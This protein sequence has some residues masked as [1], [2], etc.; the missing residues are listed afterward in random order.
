MEVV[1]TRLFLVSHDVAPMI[2]TKKRQFEQPVAGEAHPEIGM[3][4]PG[5]RKYILA[6]LKCLHMLVTEYAPALFLMG[7][8]V[9]DCHWEK[10][11]AGTGGHV[12]DLMHLQMLFLFALR[13]KRGRQQ[14]RDA[15]LLGLLQWLSNM[16]NLPA[17]TWSEEKLEASIGTVA[18]GAGG[19]MTAKNAKEL[20]DLYVT[21]RLTGDDVR[22]LDTNPMSKLYPEE[23]RRQHDEEDYQRDDALHPLRDDKGDVRQGSKPMV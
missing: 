10:H 21:Q 12:K 2:E 14:Y 17:M 13:P 1:V 22:D 20:H 5:T 7:K 23:S 4:G 11:A 3:A 9:R 6:Q 15:I 16:D 18:H 8:M 19:E